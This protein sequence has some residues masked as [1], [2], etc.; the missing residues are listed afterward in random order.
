MRG[1][2]KL[3]QHHIW[4]YLSLQPAPVVQLH[5]GGGAVL[6]HAPEAQRHGGGG[7]V[8]L[9]CDLTLYVGYILSLQGSLDAVESGQA[10]AE[11][12]GR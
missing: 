6:L 12:P 9:R 2:V 10:F 5:G 7:A 4:T 8:L 1:L 11:R 3:G